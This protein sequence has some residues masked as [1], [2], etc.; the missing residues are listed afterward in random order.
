VPTTGNPLFG[1]GTDCGNWTVSST[2]ANSGGQSLVDGV[3]VR[4]DNIT[5]LDEE[6][7]R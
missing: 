2:F 4:G 7:K 1:P 5:N 3:D 6:A